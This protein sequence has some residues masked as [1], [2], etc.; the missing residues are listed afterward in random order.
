[1]SGGE[2]NVE[3]LSHLSNFEAAQKIA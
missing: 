1:M 3:S 2:V